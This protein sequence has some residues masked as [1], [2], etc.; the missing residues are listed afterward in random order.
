MSRKHQ[1]SKTGIKLIWRFLTSTKKHIIWL[2]RIVFG[3]RKRQNVANAGFVLPT[4]AMVSVVVVLLT[5]AIM[6]RSFDRAKNASNVRV[7]E[8]VLSA[9]TPAIDRSRA[10]INKLFQ[11]I[12]LPKITPTD[13]ELYKVLDDINNIDNI[14][15]YTFADE[16]KLQ[17]SFDISGNG[18]IEQPTTSTS[19]YDYEIVNT[20]WKFP[21]DTDNN[22]KFDSYTLYGILLR[23]PRNSSGKYAR[24]RNPLEARTSPMAKGILDTDCTTN[25]NAILVGNTGWI[26]QNN[27]LKK[28]FFV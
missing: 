1:P 6:V 19:L 12:S 13:E 23:T 5:T 14:N 25:A 20:A 8:A 24:A 3:T 11:D 15:K 4:V 10:K 17:I 9:A 22:G 21:V 2:L 27:E 28:S 26:K 16:T 7:N 18:A